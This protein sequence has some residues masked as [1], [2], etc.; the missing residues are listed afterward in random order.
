MVLTLKENEVLTELSAWRELYNCFILRLSS[1][2]DN[3]NEVFIDQYRF[4]M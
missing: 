3:E 1:F 2:V 4:R